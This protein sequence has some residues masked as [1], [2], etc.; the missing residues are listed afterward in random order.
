MQLTTNTVFSCGFG[1]WTNLVPNN[2]KNVLTISKE[3]EADEVYPN[4][5][6]GNYKSIMVTN[7]KLSET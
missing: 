7:F 6:I 4:L 1:N 3:P 2:F 5:F